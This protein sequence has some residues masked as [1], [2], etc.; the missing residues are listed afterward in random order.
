[1]LPGAAGRGV[2]EFGV[3]LL[4]ALAEFVLTIF[5]FPGEVGRRALAAVFGLRRRFRRALRGLSAG[6]VR[7]LH[8]DHGR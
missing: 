3:L 1:M 8:D 2:F 4:D 5:G 6:P 7:Q